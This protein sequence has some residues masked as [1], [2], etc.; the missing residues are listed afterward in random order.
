MNSGLD[1]YH[2]LHDRGLPGAGSRRE[3]SKSWCLAAPNFYCLRGDRGLP[4]YVV[5]RI[6]RRLLRERRYIL[7]AYVARELLWP[8]APARPLWDAR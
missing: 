8:E 5:L 1:L 3:F 6:L 2:L 4:E 7:A